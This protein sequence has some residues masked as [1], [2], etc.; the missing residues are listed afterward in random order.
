MLDGTEVFHDDDQSDF[1]S[2]YNDGSDKDNYQDDPKNRMIN[3]I[4][5]D[6]GDSNDE[7]AF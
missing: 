1:H 7:A 3:M 4:T 2:D 6:D 5:Y